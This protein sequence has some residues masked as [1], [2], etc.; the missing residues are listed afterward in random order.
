MSEFVCKGKAVSR[1]IGIGKIAIL[2]NRRRL[3]RVRITDEQVSKELRKFRAAVRLAKRQLKKLASY[4]SSAIQRGIFEAQTLILEDRGFLK[5]IESKIQEEK[6]SV[7]YA[8]REVANSYASLYKEI[9]DETI[10]EKY[11]DIEDVSERI[12]SV[13][14]KQEPSATK[15][16]EGVVLVVDE[17]KPSVLVEF[18]RKNL[19]GIISENGSWTSHAFIIARELGVPAVTG[20]KDFT[21]Y[22]VGGETVI[23]DGY[24]GQVVLFPSRDTLESFS[25]KAEKYQVFLGS[26]GRELET[27]DSRKVEI[28]VNLDFIEA[29]N[30]ARSLG[31][32]GVGLYRSEFLFDQKRDFPSESEQFRAYKKITEMVGKDRVKIRTFDL[33]LEGFG[34]RFYERNPALGLRAIRL[35]LTYEKE[36]RKQIRALLRASAFGELDIVLPMISDLSEILRAKK[37]L[38]EE[39]ERLL[40]RKIEVGSPRLGIMIEVPSTVFMIE[41]IL[42]E[43]EFINLGTND[44]V[45]YIL[46]VDRDN[47]SLSN[48][49]RTLHPAVIRA[50]DIVLKKAEQRGIEV[51]VCGEMA[52]SPVYAPILVGLG[53]TKLSMNVNSI[54]RVRHIISN[55]AYEEALSVAKKVL[56][57]KSADEA[58]EIVRQ[59]FTTKWY[60]LFPSETFLQ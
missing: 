23:V 26:P 41:E 31:A 52:G 1:G 17:L 30:K 37:I 16:D 6:I 35:S 46:A 45:Q 48:W 40:S 22:V 47:E 36:F 56:S 9:K 42:E 24:G 4:E 33:S 29:Y 14:D 58:E 19:K 54:L 18:G 2:Q 8:V 38:E 11:L 21:R 15:I 12:L 50:I 28:L 25:K 57:S 60:H 20:L 51:V 5:K 32:S 13:I 49:F 55:I 34:Q 10:R 27:L 7:E 39:R 44:L 53:A 3:Y 59:D 43:V